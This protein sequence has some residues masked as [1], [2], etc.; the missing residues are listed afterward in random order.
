MMGIIHS[1]S[2]SHLESTQQILWKQGLGA[3]RGGD[4]HQ[5]GNRGGQEAEVQG[6]REMLFKHEKMSQEK[7]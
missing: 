7:M 1:A 6:A 3:C 2:R 4:K 5:C